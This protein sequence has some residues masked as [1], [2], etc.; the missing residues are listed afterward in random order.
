MLDPRIM[1]PGEEL[2]SRTDLTESEIDEIVDVMEAMRRWRLVERRMNEA[3]RK[4]MN[5]GD[6]D[7]RA[8]RYMISQQRNGVLATPSD[9]ARHLEITTASVSKM[10][11]RLVAGNHIRRLAHPQD[12]RSVAL[13]VTEETQAI[14]RRSVGHNHAQRFHAIAA[15]SSAERAA[16]I[17]FF[18]AF[19]ATEHYGIEPPTQTPRA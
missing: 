14:A 8:V 9:V 18:D 11:D 2:I 3:S 13:E 19:V 17:K 10:L 16:V 4:Y 15:L 6:N 1:D 7:M 5:L 12:R